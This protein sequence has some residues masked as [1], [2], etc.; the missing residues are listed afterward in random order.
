LF[1]IFVALHYDRNNPDK[2]DILS[3]LCIFSMVFICLFSSW[4]N[5]GLVAFCD[6]IIANGAAIDFGL[7]LFSGLSLS[8]HRTC[9][10][11]ICINEIGLQCTERKLPNNCSYI[12]GVETFHLLD[13]VGD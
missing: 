9:C 13:S 7:R 1:V 4:T 5:S 2:V 12:D 3:S 11:C 8:A 6:A 10:I